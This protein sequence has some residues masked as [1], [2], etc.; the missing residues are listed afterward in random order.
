MASKETCE[1]SATSEWL[2][3][4]RP[5]RSKGIGFPL[6]RDGHRAIPQYMPWRHPGSCVN[7]L[8]PKI[9]FNPEDVKK[10]GEFVVKLRNIPMGVLV[11]LGL[12]RAW[13][14]RFKRRL[15]DLAALFKKGYRTTP[16]YPML[17]E[18]LYLP[19]EQLEV[20]LPDEKVLAKVKATRK[21]KASTAVGTSAKI[22]YRKRHARRRQYFK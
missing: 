6:L 11:I 10:L 21:R 16:L 20:T 7:D 14:P 12:S 5:S 8:V 3:S 17:L 22:S 18:L 9:G 13:A 19:L 15:M 4:S 2:R 1:T